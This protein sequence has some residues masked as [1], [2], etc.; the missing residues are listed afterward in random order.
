VP[1]LLRGAQQA[2]APEGVPPAVLLDVRDALREGLRRCRP[3]DTLVFGNASDLED[4]FAVTGSA[5]PYHEL[6][7]TLPGTADTLDGTL[8]P[9]PT[10]GPDGA[11]RPGSPH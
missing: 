11:L 10:I 5:Q 9:G 7:P 2:T 1:P 8:R 4:L 6:G 3:G